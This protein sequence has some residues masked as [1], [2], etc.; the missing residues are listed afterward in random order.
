MWDGTDFVEEKYLSQEIARIGRIRDAKV[1]PFRDHKVY[2]LPNKSHFYFSFPVEDFLIQFGSGSFLQERFQR[3]IAFKRGNFLGAHLQP[4]DVADIQ[5][6]WQRCIV[7][8][9]VNPYLVQ[10]TKS[11]AREHF[12]IM[13]NE[14]E[15]R[16]EAIAGME[17]RTDACADYLGKQ[18]AGPP[19]GGQE[20]TW[21]DP[22]S[23]TMEELRCT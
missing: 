22:A 4:S 1:P 10:H 7:N 19:P 8:G 18:F 15:K 2:G 5:R 9:R 11:F 3:A 6:F 20:R 23:F 12:H 17:V 13:E 16:D 14:P 21:K